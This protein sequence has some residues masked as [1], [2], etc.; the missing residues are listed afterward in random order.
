LYK[1]SEERVTEY[2]RLKEISWKKSILTSKFLICI[3]IHLKKLPVF[4]QKFNSMCT[5]RVRKEFRVLNRVI[6][7]KLNGIV[8]NN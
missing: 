2:F 4:V 6:C 7:V 1:D 8:K 3:K 5:K